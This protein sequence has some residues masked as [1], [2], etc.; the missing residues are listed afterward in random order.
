MRQIKRV[1]FPVD[2]TEVNRAMAA[3]VHRVASLFGASVTLM[4]VVDPREV[5][6][7]ESY[8]LYVRSETDVLGDQLSVQRSL[9]AN[10]LLEAFPE[11]TRELHRGDP[12]RTIGAY[13]KA[14]GIDLVVMSTH[15]GRFRQMLLGST[16]ARVINDVP[17]PVLTSRH[18]DMTPPRPL[19]HRRWVV[20]L[21]PHDY[22]AVLLERSIEIA[23]QAGT[24]L[25]FL[26][27]A[28][29]S[30]ER[31][32]AYLSDLIAGVGRPEG[33]HTVRGSIKEALLAEAGNLEADALI[34]GRSRQDSPERL[35]DLTYAL[36]RDSAFP[37]IS[38]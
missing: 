14:N 18:A 12:A 21:P 11:A 17:C 38:V 35:T 37:V 31:S 33:L 24:A 10:Y 15:S 16:T 3:Y 9:L 1:L 8:E 25:S 26:H 34:V 36:V 6:F 19:A 23:K 30:S 7:A 5:S 4:H 13:T 28:P 20:A 32:R 27:V 29:D 22:A 2:F